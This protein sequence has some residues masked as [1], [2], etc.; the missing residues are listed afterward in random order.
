LE[1]GTD[2]AVVGQWIAEVTATRQA[3]EASLHQLDAASDPVS[4]EA[5]RRALEAVG[6]LAAALDGA[7]PGLRA[8]LYQEVGIEGIYDPYTRV[9]AIRADLRRR[10]VRVGGATP[11]FGIPTPDHDPGALS[12]GIAVEASITLNARATHGAPSSVPW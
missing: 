5:I 2:P 4:P 11:T 8:Q 1:A 12:S 6:G 9:V 7:D 3:A 10:M